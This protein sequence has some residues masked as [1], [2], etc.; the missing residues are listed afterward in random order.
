MDEFEAKQA[1]KE[2]EVEKGFVEEL[3]VD[4]IV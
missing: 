1:F 4:V 2:G 3:P